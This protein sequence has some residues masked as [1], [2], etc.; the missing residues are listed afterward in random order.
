MT[1]DEPDMLRVH[2]L[3]DFGDAVGVALGHGEDDRLAGKLAGL[4]LE[5]DLHDF[6]PLLAEGV[7]VADLDFDLRAGVV[8]GVGVDALLD[9]S[10][11]VLLAEIHALDAFAL[12]AGVRL[13]QAE[14]DEELVL[15]GLA[16]VVEEGRHVGIAV[17]TRGR[18]RGR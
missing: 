1:C 17:E 3:E 12:E 2:L 5:A 13:V 4:I 14:I 18:C 10:V 16:I 15:D 7:L 9:E 8:D 6:F 11:A